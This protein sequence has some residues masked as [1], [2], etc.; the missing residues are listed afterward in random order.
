VRA[1][2]GLGNPGRQYRNT[3]HNVGFMVVEAVA[4]SVGI[5]LNE[6]PGP[7]LIG[8]TAANSTPVA[9][10]EPVTFM[11]NSGIA[12]LDIT[13]RYGIS[14]DELLVVMDDFSIP[15]GNL[16]LRIRGSDGG[17]NGLA[18]ILWHLQTDKIPR[19]RCGISREVMPGGSEGL[20]DFVL[21]PF[22]PEE[23]IKVQTLIAL[24]RDAVMVALT[25]GF[26]AAMNRFNRIEE[27]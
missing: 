22:E 18:S 13:G 17:H 16:R 19:L 27:Q 7:Y 20:S 10:I 25:E 8:M 5:R 4:A 9:L 21:S 26:E 23:A 12:V 14:P 3:R 15:L 6:G 11:N 1:V 24:A 2:V